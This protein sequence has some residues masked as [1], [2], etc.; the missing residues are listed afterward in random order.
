[1]ERKISRSSCKT[2]HHLVLKATIEVVTIPEIRR[3]PSTAFGTIQVVSVYP[4]RRE[5]IIGIVKIDHVPNY[6]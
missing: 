1:M 2:A 6:S 4:I 3:V 5:R